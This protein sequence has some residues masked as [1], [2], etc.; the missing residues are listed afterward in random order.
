MQLWVLA[1]VV[2]Q[3]RNVDHA[4]I[5]SILEVLQSYPACRGLAFLGCNFGDEALLA[6]VGLMQK[7][8][9]KWW[10]GPKIQL[11]EVTAQQHEQPCAAGELPPTTKLGVQPHGN[12]AAS[13][14]EQGLGTPNSLA[15]TAA[16][17]R[18]P[19]AIDG[20]SPSLQ[21]VQLPAAEQHPLASTPA[22]PAVAE[23]PTLLPDPTPI[24]A[25]SPAHSPPPPAWAAT[26]AAASVQ[27]SL[28]PAVSISPYSAM[29]QRLQQS[30][31]RVESSMQQQ[32]QPGDLP[33]AY[34][35]STFAQPGAMF[36][37][38]F[39]ETSP[40]SSTMLPDAH[41]APAHSQAPTAGQSVHPF[42]DHASSV[43]P[44]IVRSFT[45]L[46]CHYT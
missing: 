24:Q 15:D 39:P 32:V 9:G 45:L 37:K 28:K 19:P 25:A 23:N 8:C 6:V 27:K 11:L 40:D 30:R 46:T 4:T 3:G 12:P 16:V 36:I 34:A 7:G 31:S 18:Q 1:Q 22:K 10:M 17:S 20:K 2:C 13:L 35:V 5:T 33:V 38:S 41:R 43:C 44:C 21:L 26:P 42:P 29:R 14:P